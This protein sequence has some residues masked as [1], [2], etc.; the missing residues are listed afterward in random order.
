MPSLPPTIVTQPANQ[1]IGSL[2]SATLS[3]TAT[4]TPPLTYQW[5][6]GQSGD[7]STPISGATG[8]SYTTPAALNATTSYWVAV[9]NLVTNALSLTAQSAAAVVMPTLQAPACTLALKGTGSFLTV[10]ASASCTDPQL[11]PLVT[12]LS[13][14]T[15]TPNQTNSGSLVVTKTLTPAATPYTVTVSSRDL[16]QLTGVRRCS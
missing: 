2:Q 14:G 15:G 12:T 5:Y 16:S 13:W 11:E 3:V 7:T 8:S 1:T 4:G 6:Q 9:S 10:V